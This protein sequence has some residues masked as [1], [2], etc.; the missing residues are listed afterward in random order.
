MKQQ[1]PYQTLG[2]SKAAT[3]DEIK[4][5][6]RK[7]ARKHH[8]DLNPGSKESERQFKQMQGAYEKIETPENRAKHDRG[9]ADEAAAAAE[10]AQGHRS[11][12]GPFY[13][14]TQADPG[15]RYGSRFSE[16]FDF[17][18]FASVFGG[19]G[20]T[21]A[22]GR[23]RSSDRPGADALYRLKIGFRDM[24]LGAD[25]EITLPDGRKLKIQIPAGVSSGAK[26]RFAG[27]GGTGIGKGSPGDL[28]IQIDVE[29][30]PRF[31]RNGLDL[32]MDLPIGFDEAILGG[33]VLVTTLEGSVRLKIPA[34]SS[35]DAKLRLKGKGI[36][37][38]KSGN[39]GD[40]HARLKIMLPKTIDD[41]LKEAIR[42]WTARHPHPKPEAA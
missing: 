23:G 3:Q 17:N 16:E 42:Q 40:L 32:E 19:A 36:V 13:S 25:P 22:G 26:L 20:G 28:Y 4:A 38:S 30:S 31:S 34:G 21:N 8:P 11:R 5:A 6:Y 7:L 10:A 27:M 9:E 2:V 24:A 1:D 33:E 35:T 12:R 14:E 15:A 29:D 18:D 37:D 39:R 41:E